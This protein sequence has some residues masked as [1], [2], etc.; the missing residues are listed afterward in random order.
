MYSLL[1]VKELCKMH[2]VKMKQKRK[3]DREMVQLDRQINKADLE[4]K[5][6]QQTLEVGAWPQVKRENYWKNL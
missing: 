6:L 1:A 3:T 4:I 5:I 2:P